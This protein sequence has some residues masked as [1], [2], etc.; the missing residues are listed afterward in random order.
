MIGY[1]FLILTETVLIRKAFSG[2]HFQPE[3]FWSWR[4]WDKQRG[5]VIV[6]IVMFI[7]VGMLV[8]KEWKWKGLWVAAG[9]SVGIEIL[10]LIYHLVD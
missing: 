4:A 1:A 5:Q 8:G 10:Q 3:L 9:M 2:A 6:N 7:P